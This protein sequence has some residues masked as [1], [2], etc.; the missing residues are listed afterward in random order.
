MRVLLLYPR[1]PKTYWSMHGALELVGRKVLL[2]PLGL[3]DEYIWLLM[4]NE[5]F[6]DYQATARQ[7]VEQQLALWRSPMPAVAAI[8]AAAVS[9]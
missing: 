2:P 3:I 7:Q 5:H 6:L 8:G 9:R 1:F 4:L